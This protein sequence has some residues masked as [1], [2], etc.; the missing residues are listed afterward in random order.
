MENIDP[1]SN[2]PDFKLGIEL[3]NKAI[4]KDPNFWEAHVLAAELNEKNRDLEKAIFHYK[5]ALNIH[6]THSIS[7]KTNFFV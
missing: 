7:S 1:V 3:A 6:P 4:E 5:K 2:I